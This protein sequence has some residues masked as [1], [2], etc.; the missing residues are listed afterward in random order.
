VYGH[1]HVYVYVKVIGSTCYRANV[2]KRASRG[3]S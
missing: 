1:G 3:T 2:P